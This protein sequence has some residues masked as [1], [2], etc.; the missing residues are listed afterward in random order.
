MN[1]ESN[2]KKVRKSNFELLRILAMFGI[3]IVHLQGKGIWFP[4]NSPITPIFIMGHI[5][6][7]GW[8]AQTGNWIFVLISGYFICT[9][10]FS[11][12]KVLKLWFQIYTISVL[13]GLI[14][15]FSKIPVISF[16]SYSDYATLGYF[17][18][19]KPTGMKD[20]IRCLFPCYFCNNWF[21]VSYLVFY[22]F[23]PF[24]NLFIKNISQKK[25]FQIIILMIILGTILVQI[26]NQQIFQINNL[27]LFILGYLI[28]SYIRFYDPQFLNHTKMN[29]A[30]SL[31]FILFFTFW[32]CLIYSSENT[33]IKR[34]CIGLLNFWGG[35]MN[36][37]LPLIFA[38]LIF[39]LFKNLN[40][41]Y[42]RFINL[43][44][45]TTFGVY[46]ISENFLINHFIWHRLLHS[47]FYSNTPFVLIYMIFATLIAFSVCSLLELLRKKIIE[48]PILFLIKKINSKSIEE[49]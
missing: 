42:S 20:L 16:D 33:F 21:A 2:T 39:C 48:Q 44:A 32:N 1:L 6:D 9:S 18:V 5:F 30:L 31:L 47:D 3:V 13:I 34:H 26:P 24:L 45:S 38:I 37:I 15:Y 40:I 19:A 25:H 23:V 49:V 36:K 8:L 28:A 27:F 35:G 12:R 46:L 7:S 29:I 11:Y 43:I 17:E 4:P 10:E 14:F 41:Q 22:L